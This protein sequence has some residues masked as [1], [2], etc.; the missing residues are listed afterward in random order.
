MS[1]NLARSTDAGGSHDAAARMVRS[2]AL[3]IQKDRTAVAVKRHPGMTSMELARATGMDRHMIAR[4][5][6]EL[7]REGRAWRGPKTLCPISNIN[8]C[9]WW[10]VAPGDNYTLA[11]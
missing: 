5:L 2:G 7:V 6:P 1:T 10:P 8:V 9:T 11:V 4:H 3:D